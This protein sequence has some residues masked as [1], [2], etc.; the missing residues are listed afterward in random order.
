MFDDAA[1]NICPSVLSGG[2]FVLQ[3]PEIH[4]RSKVTLRFVCDSL[5]PFVR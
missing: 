1:V 4:F 3:K 5:T 2:L